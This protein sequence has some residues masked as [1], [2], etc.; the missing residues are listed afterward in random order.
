MVDHDRSLFAAVGEIRAGVLLVFSILAAILLAAGCSSGSSDGEVVVYTSVDQPFSEPILEEFEKETGIDVR[1]VYDTE[2]TKT[3]GLTSRLRAEQGR[4][5]ADVFW[6]SE[7]AQTMGLAREGIFASY[8]SPKAREL[9]ESFKDRE[10]RWTAMGYRA[11][12]LIVNTELMA[13]ADFPSSIFDLV[14]GAVPGDRTAIA[15]PLFGTTATHAAALYSVLGPARAREYYEALKE[16]GVR[17]VDGNSVVRDMVA[18]GE[19]L[20]G[21]TDTDDAEIAQNAGDPVKVIFPDQ[22]GLGTLLIPNTVALVDGGPNS[23]NGRALVDFL[24]SKKVERML[25]GRGFLLGSLRE[26]DAEG[27]RPM[28][29]DWAKVAQQAR[30]AQRD[31]QSSLLG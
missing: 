14:N 10:S 5:Q 28:Q 12:V 23:K 30:T 8:N 27:T 15:D 4:P 20:F 11:R 6:S 16:S 19:S 24:V 13:P 1:P 31:L 3:I 9:P 21:L 22:D 17:I 7:I 26:I 29:V 2:A 18:S 25:I